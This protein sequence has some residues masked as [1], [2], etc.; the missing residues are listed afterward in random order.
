VIGAAHYNRHRLERVEAH[1]NARTSLTSASSGLMRSATSRNQ[2]VQHVRIM[3]RSLVISVL[4]RAY[5]KLEHS[6]ALNNA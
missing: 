2:H 4:H 3:D 5:L 1:V 6:Q